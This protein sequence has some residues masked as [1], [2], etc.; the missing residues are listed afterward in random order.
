MAKPFQHYCGVSLQNGVIDKKVLARIMAVSGEIGVD[1]PCESRN[2]ENTFSSL[3][4][5]TPHSAE[6]PFSHFKW[7]QRKRKAKKKKNGT[8][9]LIK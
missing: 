2:E 6:L 8:Q 3:N 9:I 1:A 7:A 4:V 5:A